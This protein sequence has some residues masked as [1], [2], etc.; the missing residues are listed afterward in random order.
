MVCCQ[1]KLTTDDAV[2]GS[3]KPLE[4]T[5]MSTSVVCV[6]IKLAAGV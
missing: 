2:G 5:R 1:S 6:A 4:V 3:D